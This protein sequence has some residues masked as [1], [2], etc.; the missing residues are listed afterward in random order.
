MISPSEAIAHALAFLAL[1]VALVAFLHSRR[2]EGVTDERTLLERVTRLETQM[3]LIYKDVS[4]A[5]SFA[6]AATLHR[7]DDANKVDEFIDKWRAHS[8]LLE[9]VPIFLEQLQRI[10]ANGANETDRYAADIMI[11]AVR[12]RFNWES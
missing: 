10:A 3:D 5:A 1:V 7:E 8:L 4:F 12:Q 2:R 11:R 6:A 9:E